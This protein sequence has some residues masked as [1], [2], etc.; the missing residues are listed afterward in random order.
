M[1]DLEITY[2][3]SID[4]LPFT[5]TISVSVGDNI[6]AL[7]AA[8]LNLEEV[9]GLNVNI[10][11]FTP[12]PAAA[13][14]AERFNR[15]ERG[16]ADRNLVFREINV[17]DALQVFLDRNNNPFV[18][19]GVGTPQ[20][21]APVTIVGPLTILAPAINNPMTLIQT[22]VTIDVTTMPVSAPIPNQV[23]PPPP[24]ANSLI[25]GFS[26]PNQPLLTITD[27]NPTPN[28]NPTALGG[29][30]SYALKVTGNMIITGTLT[31]QFSINHD[32]LLNIGSVPTDATRGDVRHVTQGD[33]HSH[34]KGTYNATLGKWVVSSATSTS[35]LGIINHF[36]LEGWG[37][38]PTQGNDF[39]PTPGVQYHVTGGDLHSHS[40]GDGAQVDHNNLKN[41]DPN[42]SNHV[43][44][45]NS[46]AHT[47]TGDG[48]TVSHTNL[49]DIE[50]SGV[51]ALHVT[52]GDGHSHSI[53]S[54]GN[55]IGDGAQI[56]HSS[57]LHISTTE[58]GAIHVTNGDAHTHSSTGD[59][60]QIDHT[61]LSNIGT[62][63]HAQI[64]AKLA[65]F[66]AAVAGTGQFTTTNPNS[67]QIQHSLGTDQ[68]N[69][70]FSL[71]SVNTTPSSSPSNIGVLYVPAAGKT[72][73]AF[74]LNRAGGASVGP[75]LPASLTTALSGSNNDLVYTAQTA[76]SA[77]NGISITY[78]LNNSITTNPTISASTTSVV[79]L[80]TSPHPSAATVQAAI[81]ANPIAS[82][83]VNVYNASGNDGT[84]AIDAYSSTH[85]TGGADSSG[86]TGLEFE[87]VLVA[88]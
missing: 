63:T 46:H 74:T 86:F 71:S 28:N 33:Y 83:I 37:T 26:N 11:L 31:A 85:L 70:L 2:P 25:K 82:A 15:L 30:P 76:G 34:R 66:K 80:F 56:D 61:T 64:D 44:G 48:G 43:T 5:T 13:T 65:T 7:R 73:S 41:V 27:I 29:V 59:G 57:L 88:K 16:I 68:F 10:G 75:A 69:V 81:L 20:V 40:V 23:S 52:Y 22:P 45:G 87:Y 77:G 4:T 60:G 18:R 84:G 62:N 72:T 32:Q 49:S 6:N 38:L 67:V 55:P 14:V 39:V 42:S 19:I 17:S 12:D 35:D 54:N 51:G 9:L 47:S 78:V 58:T 21:I 50:T 3:S 1:T 36:D 79:V 8:I 53:D 24:S